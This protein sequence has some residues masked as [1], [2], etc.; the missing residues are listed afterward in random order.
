MRVRK[1]SPRTPLMAL[2]IGLA[3]GL[4][5]TQK[6]SAQT[7]IPPP[8]DMVSWWAGDGNTN[9]TQGMNHGTLQNNAGFSPGLV[10]QAFSFAGTT[11]FVHISNSP[12]LTINSPF[13]LE[14]WF[15][16]TSTVDPTNAA[17]PGLFSKG[18]GDSVGLA[19]N[20]ARLEI[21]GPIPRAFSLTD[22]WSAGVW[23]HVAVT[24]DTTAYAIYVDGALEAIQPATHS[25]LNNNNHAQL[26]IIPGF[27]CPPSCTAFNGL[28]DEVS[29]Y[30]RALSLGEIG[31]VYNAGS[32]GKCK[33]YRPPV[34]DAH[35]ITQGPGCGDH[36]FTYRWVQS[37]DPSKVCHEPDPVKK[38]Q[39][40]IRQKDCAPGSDGCLVVNQEEAIDYA[41]SQSN[42]VIA[43][44]D[45]TVVFADWR[46]AA[47]KACENPNHR[48]AHPGACTG[49]VYGNLVQL[50]H[51]DGAVSFYAHL[52]SIDPTI[53]SGAYVRRGQVLGIIGNTGNSTGPHLHFEVRRNAVAQADGY[54]LGGQGIP[55]RTLPTTTWLA[56]DPFSPDLCQDGEHDGDA[57]GPPVP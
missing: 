30:S 45:G 25:I 2:A 55:M 4:S 31:A 52:E 34:L 21:R 32:A 56:G 35:V 6:A 17:S 5:A 41:A 40:C 22:T 29:L 48:T 7:C 37:K 14:F 18:M 10:N 33:P 38:K 57:Q 27:S 12:S 36:V 26:G 54:R 39:K 11:D 50:E 1:L 23:H 28:L 46:H 9:D 19:N 53:F 16:P 49:W 43:T 15:V 51:N 20:D 13:T 42:E 24:F 47:D 3:L 8:S 44:A